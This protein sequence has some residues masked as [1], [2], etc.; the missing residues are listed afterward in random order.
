MAEKDIALDFAASAGNAGT[1]SVGALLGAVF[2]LALFLGVAHF[3]SKEPAAAPPNIVEM[4]ALSLPMDTPPP[5]PVE[6]QPATGAAS[7]FAGLEIHASDSAVKV[8][9]VP[10][11][12]E[13]FVPGP[14]APPAAIQ[15]SQLYT[16]FRP[17]MDLSADFSRIFQQSEVDQRFA[18]LARPLPF[19]PSWVRGN[20]TSLRVVLLITVDTRGAVE[21]VRMT[22]SSG[23]PGFDAIIIRDV[24]EAWIF[25]PAIRK[26][27]K[28][29]Q[30]GEQSVRVSWTGPSSP[31]EN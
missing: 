25:S 5:R 21:S 27:R 26:G 30:V 12:L 14:S 31:F 4:R 7:P 29:R 6:S 13:E 19:I 11:D 8:A 15:T 18:V 23:N 3:E 16:E 2:T 20:A 24:R 9:V 22:E 1:E 10:P 17:T 28:V